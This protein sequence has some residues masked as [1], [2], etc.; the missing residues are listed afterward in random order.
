MEL[1]GRRWRGRLKMRYMDATDLLWQPLIKVEAERNKK[2]TTIY[3]LNLI[4]IIYKF[5]KNLVL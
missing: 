1:P 3:Q 4:T 5:L 2:M